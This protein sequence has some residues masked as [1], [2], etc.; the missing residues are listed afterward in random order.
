MKDNERE[1]CFA[2]PLMCYRMC[3]HENPQVLGQH[4]SGAIILSNFLQSCDQEFVSKVK[5]GLKSLIPMVEKS[6]QQ[7]CGNC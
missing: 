6:P 3:W 4:Q 2:K 7:R 5:A 1:G